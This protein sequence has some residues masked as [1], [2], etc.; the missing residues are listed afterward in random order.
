M[1]KIISLLLIAV[2]TQASDRSLSSQTS[3]PKPASRA[4]A[5]PKHT[6]TPT[7]ARPSKFDVIGRFK[8]LLPLPAQP[9]PAERCMV[10]ELG[11]VLSPYFVK[12]EMVRT[13]APSTS[14]FDIA[15]RLPKNQKFQE[16][17]ERGKVLA[18]IHL[19]DAWQKCHKK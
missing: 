10:T 15:Y 17:D 8:E 4:T 12:T 7:A 6:A 13:I 14:P 16:L 1:M 11:P 19:T 5:M 9:A 18:T 3:K 2:S